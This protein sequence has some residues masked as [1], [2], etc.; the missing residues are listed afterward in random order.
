MR[1]SLGREK[2]PTP[3]G[4]VALRVLKR[5]RRVRAL[6]LRSGI[7]DARFRVNPPVIHARLASTLWLFDRAIASTGA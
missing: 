6:R 5:Q 7:A 2:Q 1:R 4:S 3:T